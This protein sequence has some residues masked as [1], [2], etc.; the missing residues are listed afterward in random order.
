MV[1]NSSSSLTPARREGYRFEMSVTAELSEL[2]SA[3]RNVIA[4]LAYSVNEPEAT[5][6][7]CDDDEQRL[8]D[9]S[10]Q[11]AVGRINIASK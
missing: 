7:W 10:A 3:C 5:A 6:V 1:P 8:H 4:T 2:G 9:A 11:A